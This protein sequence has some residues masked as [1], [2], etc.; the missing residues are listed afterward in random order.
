MMNK[1]PFNMYVSIIVALIGIFIFFINKFNFIDKNKI[2][3]IYNYL[4]I[5]YLLTL[6]FVLYKTN[7]NFYKD[8]YKNIFEKNS[9]KFIYF[10]FSAMFISLTI[11]FIPPKI[12][13][14][15]FP[16]KF[17][18]LIFFQS[19]TYAAQISL[20]PLM[21]LFVKNKGAK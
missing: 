1:P 7:K 12:Y 2:I 5:F 17:N 19:L 15:I 11:S 3:L 9:N 13:F 20:T 18:G 14:Q 8:L 10:L 4:Y 21:L 16:E 6:F